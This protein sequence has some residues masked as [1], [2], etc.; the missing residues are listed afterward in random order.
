LI[1]ILIGG[2]AG[3][4]YEHNRMADPECQP[5]E[6][7]RVI[8]GDTLVTE[9]GETLRLARIDTPELASKIRPAEPRAHEAK[10]F[11][12]FLTF[13]ET[14]YIDRGTGHYGRTIAEIKANVSDLM[15]ESG[16]ADYYGS[17]PKVR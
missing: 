15:L 3:I 4:A 7:A 1:F 9:A 14:C 6:V 5:F 11:L 16:H 10:D 8:D 17:E 2:L 12:Q 13:V